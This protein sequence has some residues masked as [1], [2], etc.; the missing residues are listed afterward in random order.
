MRQVV[1]KRQLTKYKRIL[2]L[3]AVCLLLCNSSNIL[4][5]L[6]LCSDEYHHGHSHDHF[7]DHEDHG[8]EEH[9]GD[10]REPCPVCTDLLYS[11]KTCHL[12]SPTEVIRS[13]EVFLCHVESVFGYIDSRPVFS[14]RIRPPPF[15][16]SR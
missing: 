2:A 10:D 14:L 8:R 1:M 3:L 13:D 11:A 6:H 12:A 7:H 5:A 16:P 9:D 4:L 15:I